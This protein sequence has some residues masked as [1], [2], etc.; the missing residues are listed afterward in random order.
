[1]KSVISIIAFTLAFGFSVVLV[2]LIF[3]FPQTENK[4][5]VL[6]INSSHK[7][8][9]NQKQRGIESLLGQ[10][11][12]NGD[13]RNIELQKVFRESDSTSYESVI[14]DYSKL[15]GKYVDSSESINDSDVPSEL[16]REW[17][18]HMKIWRDY[19]DF[20]NKTANSTEKMSNSEF[21]QLE[22]KYNAE[23]SRTWY[24]VLDTAEDYNPGIRERLGQ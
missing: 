1:M 2:G 22:D 12:R 8:C 16:R 20:L 11:V 21:S 13:I 9:Q 19:S 3:G 23:I 4:A 24:A 18:E 10:D 6:E 5:K 17:R 15:I 7:R 14:S